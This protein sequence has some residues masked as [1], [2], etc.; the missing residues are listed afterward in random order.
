MLLHTLN[1]LILVFIA[2]SY[3]WP[4][5]TPT[6][7]VKVVSTIR[8]SYSL[9]SITCYPIYLVVRLWNTTNIASG[10]SCTS[11]VHRRLYIVCLALRPCIVV[12]TSSVLHVVRIPSVLHVIRTLL[13]VRRPSCR[14]SLQCRPN[15]VRLARRS[16]R[17]VR[18]SSVLNVVRTSHDAS[19]MR[20]YILNSRRRLE[21]GKGR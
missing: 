7:C 16:Y 5:T 10:I 17:V 18:T 3:K 9:L 4:L 20:I 15:M 8:Y 6:K 13:S 2:L 19:R 12:R 14:S 21:E 1:E 11:S